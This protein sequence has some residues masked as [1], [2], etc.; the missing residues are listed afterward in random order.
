MDDKIPAT[1]AR[2]LVSYCSFAVSNGRSPTQEELVSTTVAMY[3]LHIGRARQ[4]LIS[5]RHH[6]LMDADFELT[7]DGEDWLFEYSDWSREWISERRRQ[8]ST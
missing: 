3:G 4:V 6:W 7:N 5:A 1:A 8:R 2:A